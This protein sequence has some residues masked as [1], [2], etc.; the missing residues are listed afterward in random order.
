MKLI[1]NASNLY[2]TGVVQVAI[3]FIE[4]CLKYKENT[5]IVFLS[6]AV[7]S[8]L[9]LN[10]FPSSFSFYIFSGK[11]YNPLNWINIIKM[12]RIE[13]KFRPD[14]VFTIFGPSWWRPKAPHLQGYAYPH[15]VYTDSPIWSIMSLKERI[16]W[17]VFKMIHKRALMHSGSYFVCET[18]DVS[19]RLSSFLNV[20]MENIYTVSNTANTF[21]RDYQRNC[22]VHKESDEFRFFTMCSPYFH[23][24]LGILNQVIPLL[25][26]KCDD[27][28]FYVTF[29][30][31]DFNKIFHPSVQHRIRNVGVL[32]PKDCPDLAANCDALFLPTL[33]ECFSASYPE[34]MILDKP[35]ITSD[36]SFAHDICE[37]AALYFD[38]LDP[39]NIVDTIIKL[40]S[41][42]SLRDRLVE[43]G[44]IQLSKL[45]TPSKRAYKYLEICNN[46][47]GKN[48]C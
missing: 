40:I 34:A 44:R 48:D 5:Y 2:G 35:I 15:Y 11:L 47:S 29:K 43:N 39:Q 16:K 22:E 14:C 13:A 41:N 10:N 38:P 31:T 26:K 33:L 21:F 17:D 28:A 30:D 3:S 18:S 27:Y 45:C 37:D 1:I 36:L 6:P 42:R 20:P 9:N 12:K 23:K 4:E 24:N 32:K 46:I 25:D 19:R 7:A 8:N